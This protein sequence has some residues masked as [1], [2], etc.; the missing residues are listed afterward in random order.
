M[1][2]ITNQGLNALVTALTSGT[3]VKIS[4]F[5]YANIPGVNA[6]TLPSQD[7][8]L[9]LESQIVY[10]D[11]VFTLGKSG[12]DSAVYSSVLLPGVGDFTFNAVGLETDRGELL[13]VHY[14]DPQQKV[15]TKGAVFG[16]RIKKYF[17]IRYTNAADLTGAILEINEIAVDY[18]TTETHGLIEL[19]TAEE[20]NTGTDAAR[21]VT[22]GT[23]QAKIN[24]AV[25]KLSP[26]NHTHPY[27]PTNHIH[28]RAGEVIM[29]LDGGDYPGTL[30]LNGQAI[31]RVLFPA[32]FAKYGTK[33]GSGDGV[34]TFNLPKMDGRFPMGAS[35]SRT[36]GSMAGASVTLPAHNHQIKIQQF[37]Q[38]EGS[39]AV[40]IGHYH[41]KGSNLGSVAG[42]CAR[43]DNA[44]EY[45]YGFD[46]YAVQT[47]GN[48]TPACKPDDMAFMFRVY[49][50]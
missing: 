40:P 30:I 5:F 36:S 10:S 14:Q 38:W 37:L 46:N 49:Y 27:A 18:A 25:S 1:G 33:F 3:T 8:T 39:W 12:N 22:P 47:A 7:S 44:G 4:R 41:L 34:T 43:K 15:K 50:Q 26:L 31:S 13:S 16:N 28:S 48:S 42:P 23:L 20:V 17:V 11:P 19:A 6:Q 21:A 24:D 45:S 29:T 9:P 2:I 35:S 32:L